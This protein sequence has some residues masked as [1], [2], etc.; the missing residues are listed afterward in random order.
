VRSPLANRQRPVFEQARF[1]LNPDVAARMDDVRGARDERAVQVHGEAIGAD[2]NLDQLP[3]ASA[4]PP[5][6]PPR[7]L[8]LSMVPSN[9]G[10]NA[11]ASGA[12]ARTGIAA[13]AATP[14]AVES[15]SRRVGSDGMLTGRS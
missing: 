13:P 4:S 1:A 9:S 2:G 11:D 6:W 14:A 3:L 7:R 12:C 15:K 10:T 8:H 5:A